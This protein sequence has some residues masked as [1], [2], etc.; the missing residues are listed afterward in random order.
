MLGLSF[1]ICAAG[2]NVWHPAPRSETLAS[3]G[4]VGSFR[5]P[6]GSSL[7]VASSEDFPK[8]AIDAERRLRGFFAYHGGGQIARSPGTLLAVAGSRR[9]R[10]FCFGKPKQ[11]IVL[12]RGQTD[13]ALPKLLQSAVRERIV[14]PEAASL[15]GRLTAVSGRQTRGVLRLR[16][17]WY[18]ELP[19]GW[20][21]LEEALGSAADGPSSGI[22]LTRSIPGTL[23][24][25]G[26]RNAE[27][28]GRLRSK[29]PPRSLGADGSTV[30]AG[31]KPYG[32]LIPMPGERFL[33]VTPA[34]KSPDV[35]RR[36]RKL[37]AKDFPITHR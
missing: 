14:P 36:L 16:R 15:M 11:W 30:V 3:L 33:M 6:S 34:E 29:W 24:I 2:P 10:M 28:K 32:T 35:F 17:E 21:G 5:T 20:Y 27:L 37:R 7:E 26:G 1:A 25:E 31:G 9:L 19:A 13:A 8:D 23:L 4:I 12:D 18:V 22:V